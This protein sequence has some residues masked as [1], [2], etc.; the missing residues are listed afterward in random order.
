MKHLH[1]LM[2]VV[3]IGLFFYNS[4]ALLKG[5]PLGRAIKALS[6]VIYGLLL[7]S[8]LYLFY[9]QW[10]LRALVGIQYWPLV[11]L[12]LLCVAVALLIIAKRHKKTK[13]LVTGAWL[14]VVSILVLALTQPF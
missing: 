4:V 7:I 5:R 12:F 9:Q 2:V 14:C 13:A 11:K 8:G 6:H 3:T 10:Q 1:L